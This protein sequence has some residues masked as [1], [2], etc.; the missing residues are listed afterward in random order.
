MDYIIIDDEAT[1][2]AIIEE[3][4]SNHEDL[5]QVGVFSSPIEAIKFMNEQSVDL[6]FLDIH[7]P[8]FSGFD[9]IKTIKIQPQIILTTSDP[10]FAFEAF[11]YKS[12]IDY[13]VKPIAVHR[14]DRAIEKARVAFQKLKLNLKIQT[15][16]LNDHFFININKKLIKIDFNDLC[17]IEAKGDYVHVKS[18]H[19]DYIV[20]NT[21]KSISEKLP[22]ELFFKVHRSYVVN[23]KKIE[24][25]E[26]NSVI[27]NK[28]TIPV[29]KAKKKELFTKL[30]LL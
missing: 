27:I 5:N 29:G 22:E 19:S 15:S 1:A 9:V 17:F 6:I 11:D 16:N 30:H 8:D 21:L 20:H 24:Q 14:F 12:I 10:N 25:I 23:L 18:V 13:L 2:R 28:V 3:L 4:C 26:E 7:M